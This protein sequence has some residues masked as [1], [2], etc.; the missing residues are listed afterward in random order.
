MPDF[1]IVGAG[2]AGSIL[3]ARLSENPAN[4]VVLLEAGPDYPGEAQTPP[5]ILDSRNLAGMDHDWQYMASPVDDRTIPY[6]RGKIVGGT[7]AINAALWQW[8][9]SVDFEAWEQLGNPEWSWTKVAPFYRCLEAD[10]DGHGDQHGRGG[11][12]PVERYCS[13][14]LIPIQRAFHDACRQNGFPE[15]ADHNALN[16]SGVGAWPMNRRGQTRISSALSHLGPARSRS[17]LT[18]KPSIMVD[19]LVI[20]GSQ[21]TGLRLTDGSVVRGRRIIL[22][23]G[24]IGSAAILLRSGI[25]PRQ[26]LEAIG[27]E[28]HLDRP[29]VGAQLWDHAAVPIRLVPNPGECVIGRDPRFQA[30]ARFT[31]P[32]S[33]HADDMQLVMTSHLDLSA[34]PALM[35]EAGVPTVAVLRAALMVPHGYGRLTLTSQDPEAN[36]KIELNY[37]SDSEDMRRLMEATR[38]G[39]K[40]VCSEAMTTAY[41]RVLGLDER[42]VMSDR[43]L[44]DYIRANIET[45]CHASGLAPIGPADSAHAVVDQHCKLHGLENLWVADASVFPV[46]P[47][48]VPNMTVMMIAERVA[49][50]LTSS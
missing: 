21:V 29:G 33:S 4:N 46:I 31:A 16:G 19:R 9:R 40:I 25:G 47:G 18:I 32:N 44:Q 38:L 43:L 8:G 41:Q 42:I 12:I 15:V 34:S 7:A 3:A 20:D 30:L 5:D 36:P 50:W 39:W 2:S 37:A 10:T 49:H 26:D 17:N 13:A 24:S 35:E 22:S 48:V 11:P 28:V 14:D 27:I 1:L 45:Y 23:A 6:R